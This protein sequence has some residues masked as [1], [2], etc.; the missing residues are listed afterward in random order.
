MARD[1]Q[2]AERA[3]PAK[4]AGCGRDAC[5]IGESV[6]FA[7]LMRA[8]T[9]PRSVSDVRWRIE[10]RRRADAQRYTLGVNPD[11]VFTCRRR[12]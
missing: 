10:L 2:R 11:Y 4:E 5:S 1:G 6:T 8:K 3:S 12:G 9:K 7:Q